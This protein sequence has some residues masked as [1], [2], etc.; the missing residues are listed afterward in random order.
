MVEL[1]FKINCCEIDREGNIFFK[2]EGEVL[3]LGELKNFKIENGTLIVDIKKDKENNSS[4]FLDVKVN[5]V[6]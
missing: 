1:Y 4:R 3:K 6:E 2:S 5:Y